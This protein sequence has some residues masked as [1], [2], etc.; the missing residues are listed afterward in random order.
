MDEKWTKIIGI[1]ILI[2][3]VIWMSVF[4]LHQDLKIIACNVGQGDAILITKQSSQILIDGGP[5]NKVMDCLSKYMPFWDNKIE[6][7]ILTHPQADHYSGLLEVFRDYDVDYYF[8]PS[9]A[10]SSQNYK[11]LNT[12][13]QNKAKHIISPVEGQKI[14]LGLIYLDILWPSEQFIAENLTPLAQISDNQNQ[15]VLGTT[16]SKLDPNRFSSTVLLNYQSFKGIFTG[17]LD[18]QSEN[19]LNSNMQL[20]HVTL[21]KVPHHGSK[22]GLTQDFLN[23]ISP[24]IALISVGK[25]NSYGH[26]NKEVI[27]MLSKANVKVYRTDELG[28]IVVSTNGSNY[29]IK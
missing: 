10:S 11:V 25:N 18:P 26:P 24:Q 17:D 9:L 27:D 12:L 21:L 5:G 29:K 7:V 6:I 14:K 13:A 1:Q 22:N 3:A 23:A 15:S 16:T 8:A 2:L 20:P 4:S 19:I 28:D